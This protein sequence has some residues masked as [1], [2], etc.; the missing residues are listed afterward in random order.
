MD[1]IQKLE[2]Q[3]TQAA[4]EYR[5]M[6]EDDSLDWK[7]ADV[8]QKEGNL[9]M[10]IQ[11]LDARIEAAKK[12]EDLNIETA[13]KDAA[14]EQGVSLDGKVSQVDKDMAAFHEFL[15]AKT[16]GVALSEESAKIM[17]VHPE[18]LRPIKQAIDTADSARG[19]I[20]IPT[21][22]ST[23]VRERMKAYSVWR[24][25]GATV[26][27]SA[28]GADVVIVTE[29]DTGNVGEIVQAGDNEEDPIPAARRVGRQGRSFGS[30]TLKTD[31]YSSKRVRMS[32]QYVQ[33]T[34]TPSVVSRMANKLGER[35]GRAQEMAFAYGDASGGITGCQ[36]TGYREAN[37]GRVGDVALA[38]IGS[39]D[40]K[41]RDG[42]V[43]E[44]WA[45]AFATGI[46]EAYWPGS[47]LMVN[48]KTLGENI[49]T[50]K[51]SQGRPAYIPSLT[52][53][54]P[55][56][57][58]GRRIFVQPQLSDIGT[59]MTIGIYCQP[60]FFE[61]RDVTGF[62]YRTVDSDT[63][64]VEAYMSSHYGF[65]RTAFGVA[66]PSDGFTRINTAP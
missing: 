15:K 37:P 46:D 27:V 63:E 60:S 62:E 42:I 26:E 51:D 65:Q 23:M 40:G 56:M 1:A 4:V 20:S 9:R 64:N 50:L 53:G 55:G 49:W 35:I 33:D 45:G 8:V 16:S 6:T 52:A 22:I 29:D 38:A 7:D 14:D 39:K 32:R 12:A 36:N 57:L 3:R 31:L 10:D 28:T 34:A 19:G 2:S 30:V 25:A 43:V 66:A 5:K 13:F 61:I 17:Q 47:I 11:A 18:T 41:T 21:T 44:H 48:A 58:L 24:R 59:N 54:E